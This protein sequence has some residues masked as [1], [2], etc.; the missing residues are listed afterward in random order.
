MKKAAIILTALIFISFSCKKEYK[1]YAFYMT[2]TV[3]VTYPGNEN[4]EF[5]VSSSVVDIYS[6]RVFEEE[7]TTADLIEEITIE[8]VQLASSNL[9]NFNN[10]E[11]Q[12]L[13]EGLN[14]VDM[15]N[16]ETLTFQN[17]GESVLLSVSTEK[18]DDFIKASKFTIKTTG[19][20]VGTTP[21]QGL[22][23]V[24]NLRFLVKTY[25]K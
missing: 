4:D 12:I 15:A 5:E 9:S 10:L 23:V 11:L 22:K 13:S 8:E 3:E 2:K 16:A 14:E 21:T 25:V 19:E 1:F 6:E 18:M 17:D 20:Y 7:G 24:Y